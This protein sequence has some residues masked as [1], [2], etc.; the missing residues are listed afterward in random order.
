MRIK[1]RE[2]YSYT[3]FHTL[4]VPGPGEFAKAMQPLEA[5][6]KVTS[7][8][9]LTNALPYFM[10]GY[11]I[12]LPG[13]MRDTDALPPPTSPPRASTAVPPLPP[14]GGVAAAGTGADA[15]GPAGVAAE[16]GGSVPGAGRTASITGMNSAGPGFSTVLPGATSAGGDASRRLGRGRRD[17]AASMDMRGE[18]RARV[19]EHFDQLVKMCRPK[20]SAPVARR[21]GDVH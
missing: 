5:S 20:A 7:T 8:C 1:S 19:L 10:E 6:I 13:G 16:L 17:A 15:A 18:D 4:E 14:L 11:L 12:T 9:S 2:E 3:T 21:A